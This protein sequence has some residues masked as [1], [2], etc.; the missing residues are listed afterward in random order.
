MDYKKAILQ[1]INE[2]KAKLESARLLYLDLLR[3]SSELYETEKALRSLILDE[4]QG[5]EVDRNRQSELYKRKENILRALNVPKEALEPPPNCEICHDTGLIDG[6]PCPCIIHKCASDAMES[7]ITFDNSDLSAFPIA[8]RERIERVYKTAQSFC[9][10]FPKTNKLNLL[11]MGKCGSG[12]SFIASC[13]ASKIAQNGYSVLMISAFAFVNRMHKYHT[14]F[15]ETKLSYLDPLLDCDLLI[16]DDLGTETMMKNITV[17]YIFHVINE[18]MT[19]KKHT[20]FTTN[21]DD[22]MLLSRYGERTYS[23][24]FGSNQSAGFALSNEDLRK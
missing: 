19:A 6:K 21:L 8:E 1:V 7:G 5:K 22:E 11:F 20:V 9:D 23:R 4:A 13:I 2:R 3:K 18:R 17:N 15:D 24:L 14:T 10:K 12:K 16:I